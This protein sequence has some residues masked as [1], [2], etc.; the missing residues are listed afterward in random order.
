[1]STTT[2]QTSGKKDSEISP[3]SPR[4]QGDV[5][6]RQ[7]PGRYTPLVCGQADNEADALP[8]NRGP[9]FML[10]ATHSGAG[11]TTLTLGLL[12]ALMNK[13]LNVQ[14][15]KCGPDFIDPTLHKLVTGKESRNLDIRMCGRSFVQACFSTHSQQAD[16]SIIEGVMGLFDGKSGVG[17]PGS[18]ADLAR[19]LELPVI[20]VVSSTRY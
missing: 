4:I 11:K 10:A 6:A 5:D 3:S 13:G 12:A 8:C 2:S 1:M 16:I 20:L 9:A 15:F 7:R 17:G 19:C 18:T 14:P